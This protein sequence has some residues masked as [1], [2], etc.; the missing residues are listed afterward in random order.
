MP[1][2]GLLVQM[3]GSP[4]RWFG[5]SKSCLIAAID[6]ANSELH[7]EFFP[8]ETALGCMKVVKDLIKKRGVFKTLYV[9]RAG[10]F[11]GP[12]R[13][14]F[15]QVQRA[16]K[17]L[18]IEIIFANSA[19]GK[20]RIERSFN[21]LQDRLIPELRIKNITCMEAA[22][23]YLQKIFIPRYWN[24]KLTVKPESSTS[25][26]NEVPS[27]ISLDEIFVIKEYRK[28]RNDHTF[29][30]NNKICNWPG[31][32]GVNLKLFLRKVKKYLT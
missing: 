13:C 19:E 6:D 11:S 18:G 3:D 7:A 4:H 14:H 17:E 23:G 8:S 24:K 27:H 28:T 1:S 2:P 31:V 26:Y 10:I 5:D 22:N 16:C 15:S 12:K 20:G 30:Y 25:E 32:V 9:D 29:S 21:T